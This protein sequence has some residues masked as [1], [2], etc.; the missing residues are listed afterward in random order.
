VDATLTRLAAYV[1]AAGAGDPAKLASSGFEQRAGPA[2]VG[3]LPQV[4]SLAA[5]AGDHDGTL[6]LA[7]DRV[8][9]ATGYEVYRSTDVTQPAG[10]AFACSCARSSA[11][12]EGLASGTRHWFRVRAVGAAGPGPWSDPATKI[13]P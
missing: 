9:G 13:A 5:T 7:W 2:P 1:E 12:V 8:P 4:E 6:D 11:T 10:W 3:P